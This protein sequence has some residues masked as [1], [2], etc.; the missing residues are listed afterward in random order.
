MKRNVLI[1]A[2]IVWKI[3][4]LVVAFWAISAIRYKPKFSAFNSSYGQRFPMIVTIW[5]NFDGMHYLEVAQNGYKPTLLPFFPLYPL[6]I[7]FFYG[8]NHYSWILTAI[9]LS[10]VAFFAMIPF[11]IW[12]AKKE[13]LNLNLF[14]LLLLTF[15]TSFFFGAVYNDALFFFF[16]TLTLF[17]SRKD[18]WILACLTASLATLTRLNGLALFPYLVTVMLMP[19]DANILETW[20]VKKICLDILKNVS[21]LFKKWQ[22]WITVSI[23]LT[24]IGY[25]VFIQ[26]TYG[27]WHLLFNA[28]DI[29]G[30][31]SVVFPLQPIWRYLKIFVS[32]SPTQLNFWVA[33]IELFFFLFYCVAICWSIKKIFFPYWVFLF[34]S[35]LIPA[36]T[37]TYQGMPRYG[38]HLFPLFLILTLFF[39]PR[40]RKKWLG[41]WLILM[42]GLFIFIET[43]FTRGFF[44]S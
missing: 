6:A 40:S 36:L 39:S 37:G 23:P 27:N 26:Q 33:A 30:Q 38:L 3:F 11:L 32:I 43:L 42:L 1:A 44:I 24:F 21:S 17:F 31:S 34:C 20:E 4:I 5:G 14:F 25:L 29:W 16:A 18:A 35:I 8:L 2:I 41:A 19:K 15:P 13:G 9:T 10:H 22:L 12:L 7:R 28:M